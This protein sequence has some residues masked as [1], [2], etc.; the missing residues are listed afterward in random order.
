MR[1]LG[2][3]RRS[4]D[5]RRSR[6]RRREKRCVCAREKRCVCAAGGGG[7]GWGVEGESAIKSFQACTKDGALRW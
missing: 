7:G 6:K 5:G 2:G 3:P 4:E 1:R